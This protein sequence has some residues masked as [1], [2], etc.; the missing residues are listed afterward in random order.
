M[1][2]KENL[3]I[4]IGELSEAHIIDMENHIGNYISK[5]CSL[6]PDISK[7]IMYASKEAYYMALKTIEQAAVNSCLED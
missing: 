3:S 5:Q 7:A 4:M 6:A 1:L 2:D